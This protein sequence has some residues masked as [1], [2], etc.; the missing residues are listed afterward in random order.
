MR[1]RCLFCLRPPGTPCPGGCFFDNDG[2]AHRVVVASTMGRP[3]V[4]K[5]SALGSIRFSFWVCDDLT[6]WRSYVIIQVRARA[7]FVRVRVGKLYFGELL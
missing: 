7:R 3:V 5:R 6:V 1:K 2:S 4:S